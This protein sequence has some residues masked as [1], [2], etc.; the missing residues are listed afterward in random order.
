M[1]D[2][3]DGKQQQLAVMETAVR[4][5]RCGDGDV[6]YGFTPPR[7]PPPRRRRKIMV[8]FLAFDGRT[9]GL[10][11]GEHERVFLPV[12]TASDYLSDL[13]ISRVEQDK[14]LNFI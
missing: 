1:S 12:I 10:A 14:L 13:L 7:R 4:D 2:D 9:C 5:F 11:I 8:G 3:L 6:S